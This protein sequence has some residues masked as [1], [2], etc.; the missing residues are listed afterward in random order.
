MRLLMGFYDRVGPSAEWQQYEE[1]RKAW[2][3]R[4]KAAKQ[5]CGLIE[6]DALQDRAHDELNYAI[7]K[8]ANTRATTI[9]G[10]RCKARLAK[11]M[12]ENDHVIASL[13]DDL[14]AVQS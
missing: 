10:L 4:Y 6:A 14:A 7:E 11:M 1:A 12:D 2:Q 5:E 13:L 9:E 8:L 3:F